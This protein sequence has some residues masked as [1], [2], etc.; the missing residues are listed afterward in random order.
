M[1]INNNSRRRH[2]REEE[3]NLG[4]ALIVNNGTFPIRR[5]MIDN[6]LDDRQYRYL[7]LTKKKKK[8]PIKQP[9]KFGA[10]LKNSIV[11]YYVLCKL[12]EIRNSIS[13]FVY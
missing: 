7:V 10:V 6:Y 4:L 5:R 1:W 2:S 3:K 12:D 13:G 11:I 8:T 9:V